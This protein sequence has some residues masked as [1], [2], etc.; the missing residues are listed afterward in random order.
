MKH[1][2][3]M[4]FAWS[5]LAEPNLMNAEGLPAGAFRAGTAPKR[6]LPLKAPKAKDHQ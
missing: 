6:D 2:V 4:R 3:A 1:P 5:M